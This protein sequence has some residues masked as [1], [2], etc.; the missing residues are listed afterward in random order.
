MLAQLKLLKSLEQD[1]AR[2]TQEL[3][4]QRQDPVDSVRAE[5]EA[6]VRRLAAEQSELAGLIRKFVEKT[7]GAAD[8]PTNRPPSRGP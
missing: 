2:R 7:A 6:D 5:A 3:D 1:L 4:H 8:A